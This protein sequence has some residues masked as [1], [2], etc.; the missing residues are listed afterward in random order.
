MQDVTSRLYPQ[1]HAS[2]VGEGRTYKR[3]VNSA[4]SKHAKGVNAPQNWRLPQT[5]YFWISAVRATF[6]ALMLFLIGSNYA[7]LLCI[8]PTYSES[9]SSTW[10]KQFKVGSFSFPRRFI[11]FVG[12][13]FNVK[14]GPYW[15]C[16][17]WC[18]QLAIVFQS[19]RS[20]QQP[21][22]DSKTAG[23]WTKKCRCQNSASAATTG[24]GKLWF[25]A[26]F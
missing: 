9:V 2:F 26:P 23:S 22:S 8:A 16:V 1:P 12:D 10:S 25:S 3:S 7:P 15:L 4:Q 20:F 24:R 14:M 17:G 18:T 13:R 11:F 5:I 19:Y 21:K 6:L